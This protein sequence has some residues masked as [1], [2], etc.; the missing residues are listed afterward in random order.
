LVDIFQFNFL[1]VQRSASVE[2]KHVH[3]SLSA[4]QEPQILLPHY[5]KPWLPSAKML[6]KAANAAGTTLPLII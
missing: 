2:P 5:P 1:P 4:T 3:F 6:Q